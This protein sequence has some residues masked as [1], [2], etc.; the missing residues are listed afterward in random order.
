MCGKTHT[1]VRPSPP[2]AQ[3][4]MH[5]LTL[6][7]APSTATYNKTLRK[8]T[9]CSKGC[10]ETHISILYTSQKLNTCNFTNILGI[11]KQSENLS[12]PMTEQFRKIIY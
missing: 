10:H 9:T 2:P 11:T 6:S 5:F 1:R 8:A 3:E 12:F 4:L 7:R